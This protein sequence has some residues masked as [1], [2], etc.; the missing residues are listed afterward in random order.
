MS[1]EIA[2]ERLDLDQALQTRDVEMMFKIA[3][4]TEDEELYV[5]AQKWEKEDWAHDNQKDND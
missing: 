1:Y 2:D 4:A 5:L 3:D